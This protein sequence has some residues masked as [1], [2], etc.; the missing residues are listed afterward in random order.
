VRLS[1]SQC[2]IGRRGSCYQHGKGR[3][4]ELLVAQKAE[5]DRV[6]ARQNVTCGHPRRPFAFTVT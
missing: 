2:G 6:P 3:L 4:A 1:F 5:T